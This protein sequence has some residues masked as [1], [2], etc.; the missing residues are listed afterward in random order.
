M[1]MEASGSGAFMFNRLSLKYRVIKLMVKT[2]AM[3]YP[4]VIRM[5]FLVATLPKQ[6][7]LDRIFII[8]SDHDHPLIQSQAHFQFSILLLLLLSIPEPDE[9]VA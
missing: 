3:R 2:V 9:A 5:D 7:R 4:H 6:Y 1:N 8:N